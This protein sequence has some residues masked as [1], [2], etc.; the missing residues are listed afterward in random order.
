MRCTRVEK[1]LP[2]QVAGDLAGRRAR[3]VAN[4]LTTCAE[5]RRS[6][7]RYD[8]SRNLLREAALPPDFDGAFYEDIRRSVL[9]RIKRDRTLAPPAPAG[10]A[11]LF[12]AR[13]AYA[14]SLAFIVLAAALALHSYTRRTSDDS[15]RDKITANVNLE[16]AAPPGAT[17]ETTRATRRGDDPQTLS[18]INERAR[19][20]AGKGAR[21]AVKSSLPKR[22][23]IEGNARDAVRPDFGLTKHTP[24][25]VERNSLAPNLARRAQ[26]NAE[27][28][29]VR[30]VTETAESEVSRIEIQTSDP[31][32][33]IIWL[34]PRPDAVAQPLK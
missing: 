14:A 25:R 31:N 29:A 10:F 26:P 16:R 28:L 7:S 2:L 3:A 15:A 1:L 17:P 11:S 24:S 13:L 9:E 6:A 21:A 8:A 33:R 23:T 22:G 18:S 12:N 32:I 19:D 27:E 5:C 4:H 20:R 34:S 30:D